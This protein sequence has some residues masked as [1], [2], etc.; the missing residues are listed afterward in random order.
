MKNSSHTLLFDDIYKYGIGL[1]IAILGLFHA[2]MFILLSVY[3]FIMRKQI[4]LFL[5]CFLFLIL[6]LPYGLTERK[7]DENIDQIYK[8]IDIDQYDHYERLTIKKSYHK[9]HLYVYEESYQIGDKLWITGK[10][11]PYKEETSLHGFNLKRYFLSHGVYGKIDADSVIFVNHQFHL[12]NLRY[13]IINMK[14]KEDDSSYIYAFLFGE[15]IKDEDIKSIYENFSIIYLFTVSGMHIYVLIRGIKKILFLLN[16]RL[17]SQH[18]IILTL[19]MIVCFLNQFQYAVL[20]VLFIYMITILNK[21][22]KLYLGHLDIIFIA[23]YL[24]LLINI[25]Y[26]YHQGFLMTFIILI[27]IELLHPLYQSLHPFLKS[28]C[29]SMII[30]AV[31]IPF[32]SMIQVLLIMCLPVIIILVIYIMYPLAILSFISANFLMIFNNLTHIFESFIEIL[33][34]KQITFYMPAFTIFMTLT[35]YA[36]LIWICFGK[37]KI[38]IFRRTFLSAIVIIFLMIFQ[39]QSYEERIIFLDVGQGDTTIIQ[40]HSCHMMIDSYHGSF[41]YLKDHGINHLDYLI[42]THSDEDHILEAIHITKKIR[43]NNVLLSLYDNNYPNFQQKPIK[44]KAYDQLMCGDIKIDIL[45]P[46]RAYEKDNDNSIVLKFNY[47][48]KDFLFT[49]DIE[50]EAEQD[51]LNIHKENLKS[52]VIKIPH[53][54]SITSSSEVFIK[55]VNPTYGIISLKT[56]NRY[57]FPNQDVL[58]RYIK[59]QVVIYRTDQQ[60]T[61]IYHGK[62]RKEKW[63]SYLSI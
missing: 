34:M 46:L 4:N 32:L 22:Y 45:G 20:R 61:I 10:Y 58:F 49:G 53:H 5:F 52:D 21:K 42:L 35:Y 33:S 13:D 7:I 19:L 23:F 51:L 17:L 63:T 6:Y 3:M 36:L 57:G 40:T 27:S 26:I 9:F 30:T 8:V 62:K 1:F 11:L 2:W 48:D 25:H 56:P 59:N 44:V 37:H 60:G 16:F 28:L 14:Q 43:V 47:D 55:Y 54:G 50:L 31:M 39:V 18:I 12:N 38:R 29:L 24:I 15:N 41:E